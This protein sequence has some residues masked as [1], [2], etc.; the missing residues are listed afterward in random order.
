M[1]KIDKMT[2]EE[3]RALIRKGEWQKPTSGLAM[4]YA[5]ANLVVLPKKYAFDFLLF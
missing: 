3:V 5:Q 2:P 1:K 4:G